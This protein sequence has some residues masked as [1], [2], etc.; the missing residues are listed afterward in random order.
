M[1]KKEKKLIKKW[2]KTLNK[3]KRPK[4]K[5][6]KERFIFVLIQDDLI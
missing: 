2:K 5:S 3:G 6:L 1:N 4:F